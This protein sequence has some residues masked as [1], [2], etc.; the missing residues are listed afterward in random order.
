MK[1]LISF[2]ISFQVPRHPFDWPRF[3]NSNPIPAFWEAEF[4]LF[5]PWQSPASQ[6]IIDTY[7]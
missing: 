3:A 5:S 2:Q 7:D 6:Y 1:N 4:P